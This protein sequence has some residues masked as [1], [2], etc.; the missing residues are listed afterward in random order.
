[1]LAAP[2]VVAL[3]RSPDLPTSDFLHR[4]VSLSQVPQ[5]MHERLRYILFVPLGALLVVFVR[6]TLGIR[7]LG[8]FRSILLALA[9]QI[10]GVMLGLAFFILVVA[11]IVVIRPVIRG[12]RMPYFGRVSLTLSVVAAI[13]VAAILTGVSLDLEPL[14]TVAYFP[15][16]VLCLA[17]EGFARTMAKEG[18]RSAVWRGG[19]TALVAVIIT[20]LSEIGALRRALL[21][22]PELLVLQIAAI[23]LIARFM[24]FRLLQGLNPPAESRRDRRLQKELRAGGGAET[25]AQAAVG[26][27]G[28]RS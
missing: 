22:F 20:L 15:I 10:T 13:L 3:L 26:D 14:R 11:S 28:E 16:V 12:L 1:M 25:A 4:Y 18:W 24:P 27:A 21:G 17:G 8:P 6:V 9:Y 19:M 2:I 7:V 5:E 23:I